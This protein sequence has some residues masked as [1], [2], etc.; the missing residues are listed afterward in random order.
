MVY[1]YRNWGRRFPTQQE[2]DFKRSDN[3][4]YES[5]IL[6]PDH[7]TYRLFFNRW[8]GKLVLGLE[9]KSN[10][11]M[12]EHFFFFQTLWLVYSTWMLKSNYLGCVERLTVP[13]PENQVYSPDNYSRA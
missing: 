8:L 1:A 11:I 4:T 10:K 6:S 5:V 13:N 7:V 12:G 3:V 2:V 9:E